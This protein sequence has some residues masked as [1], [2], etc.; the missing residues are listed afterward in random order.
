MSSFSSCPDP[1]RAQRNI[2][3][4]LEQ[5][6]NY[7]DRLFLYEKE[8]AMLFSYSQFLANFSIS[9][10]EK[11]FAALD[12]I[13]LKLKE[14][15][16]RRE[17]A[18]ILSLCDDIS[19]AMHEVRVFKKSKL[20]QITLRDILL[21][22][23]TQS[24]LYDLSIL[25]EAIL[26]LSFEFLFEL[27]SYRY[28]YIENNGL[29]VLGLGKLGAR[30]LNYSSDVDL[31]FVYR[32]EG[33]SAGVVSPNG[34]VVN[35]LT[36]PEYYAKFVEEYARFLSKLTEDGFIYRVDLRLRP[37]GQ[38][39]PIVMSLRAYEEYYESWGQLWERAALLR[40][41]P[42]AGDMT[43][44]KEFCDSLKP[45]VYRK[46]LDTETINALRNMKAQVEQ[47]K[48][49]TISRDI[50]RGYGGIREIEFFIQIFQLIYGGREPIIRDRSTL[51]SL[52]RLLEKKLVGPED[53]QRLFEG[54]IFLRTLE[55]R[56]QQAND[57][58][59]HSLPS[60]DKEMLILAKKM[61]YQD[62]S[63][64]LNALGEIRKNVRSIYD[65]LLESRE[66]IS[67]DFG[68][69]DNYYWDADSPIES[70]LM[71]EL[72]ET[73]I[74]DKNRAIYCLM[75]IRNNMASFQTLRGRR[76][77]E[78]IV[79]RFLRAAIHTGNPDKA[80]AQLVDLCQVLA[81][82]ESY[83]ESVI[84]RESIVPEVVFVLSQSEYI[85]RILLS[86]AEY[87]D[88]LLLGTVNRVPQ[89][90][91]RRELALCSKDYR[92]STAIRI[93]KK[94]KEIA[95]GIGFLSKKIG[96]GLLTRGLTNTAEA[97]LNA[98]RQR[99]LD[100]SLGDDNNPAIIAYGKLGAREIIFNS[101]L[102]IVFVTLKEP[103]DQ[104]TKSCQTLLRD[105][106]SY[107]KEGYLYKFDTRL[108]PEGSKGVLVISLEA[109]KKY[110]LHTAR[111]WEIQALIKA[112]PVGASRAVASKF[113]HM[114]KEVLQH[115]GPKIGREE[116]LAM[117][118]RICR[119][120]SKETEDTINI[121]LGRGGIKDIEFT[122]Q[123]LQLIHSKTYPSVLCQGTLDGIRR[124]CRIG[125]I[126]SKY[127]HD[128]RESYIF[129]REIETL[130]RLR[131]ETFLR[132]SGQG[133][134]E[135]SSFFK[136]DQE[137][138]MKRLQNTRRYNEEF[139]YKHLS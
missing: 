86:R 95:L 98:L 42:V 97:I 102:D 59:T 31:L 82:N 118:E 137:G 92:E 90:G 74:V 23:D 79:P 131:N 2:V 106:M 49:N 108:R 43:L 1:E 130:Q 66:S 75:K 112:R 51:V 47:I 22:Q 50:K 4:F 44:G 34:S 63:S 65:S 93:F 64:F 136:M 54:Y 76:L 5:N 111:A 138:F 24:V 27:F 103:S 68:L 39:G 129:L 36:A 133:L 135:L 109:L 16:L 121:K 94:K 11:L 38:K 37:Q 26:S 53:F 122:I 33:E 28:G 9:F 7:K 89:F 58:Q 29:A 72:T 124:L 21:L 25:A 105:L 15:T 6:P 81:T 91:L 12:N 13:D 101:D 119:E 110:Y 35:R 20:L 115:R 127:S 32:N 114:R 107:T 116:V 87:L 84:Q 67:I 132:T 99:T 128:L 96:L 134:I 70:L 46:Y 55:N 88:T 61:G 139:L 45:F 62:A 19:E 113:M 3:T 8:V 10:P 104:D 17:L 80:L 78:L 120:L 52:N 125:C 69:L 60:S 123:Y 71:Q 126:D 40:T 77:M 85:S 14:T 57:L 41:M 48:P 18:E 30:E 73:K 56:L 117:R 83:L 100:R